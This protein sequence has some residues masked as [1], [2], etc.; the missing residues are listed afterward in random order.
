[1][2]KSTR[3]LL[4]MFA[5][6]CL[7]CGVLG[8]AMSM[9][10][11]TT[12]SNDANYNQLLAAAQHLG[13]QGQRGASDDWDLQVFPNSGEKIILT[14]NLNSHTIQ[15]LCEGGRFEED[16]DLCVSEVERLCQTAFN[17][18]CEDF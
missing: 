6:I 4:A 11:T 18:S 1:M 3:L 9:N 13:W 8:T 12:P 15:Y 2:K 7:A 10:M 16:E 17:D 14:E 5:A